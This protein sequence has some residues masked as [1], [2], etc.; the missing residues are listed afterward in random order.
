MGEVSSVKRVWVPNVVS[1][2]RLGKRWTFLSHSVERRRGGELKKRRVETCV[3]V[4]IG[5]S[6]GSA[7]KTVF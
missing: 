7:G 2:A 4:P 6:A 5:I 3:S 1:R